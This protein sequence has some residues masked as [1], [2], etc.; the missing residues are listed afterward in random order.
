MQQTKTHK[1]DYYQLFFLQSHMFW[2]GSRNGS[3]RLFFYAPTDHEYDRFSLNPVSKIY[4]ESESILKNRRSNFRV[5]T[6]YLF[7]G[8]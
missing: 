7:P 4:F 2:A 1:N 8:E 3:L 5:L 6:V